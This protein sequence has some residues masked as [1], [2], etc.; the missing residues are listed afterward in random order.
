MELNDENASMTLDAL[1]SGIGN[2]AE[3]AKK[4]DEFNKNTRGAVAYLGNTHQD[5]NYTKFKGYFEDFW[6]KEPEF[7]AEV[8]NFRSYLEEEK[9]RT[10]LYIAHGNTLK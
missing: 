10:E 7:K 6:R 9:K 8:D 2:F 5:Q 1:V 4:L 3:Y